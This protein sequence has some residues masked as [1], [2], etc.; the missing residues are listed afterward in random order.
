MSQFEVKLQFQ[1]YSNEYSALRVDADTEE[2]AIGAAKAY[3]KDNWKGDGEPVEIDRVTLTKKPRFKC[4]SCVLVGDQNDD[5]QTDN[6]E[7]DETPT[8]VVETNAEVVEE[9]LSEA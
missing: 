6:V 4:E 9:V 3:L 2:E 7:T 1:T 5:V 8:D